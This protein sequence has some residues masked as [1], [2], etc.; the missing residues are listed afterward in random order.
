[1]KFKFKLLIIPAV[2]IAALFFF[3][4]RISENIFSLSAATVEMSEPT[5]PVITIDVN[6]NEINRLHGYVSNLDEMIVRETITPINS[7]KTLTVLIDEKELIV[8]KLKY[9]IYNIEGREVE[10]DTF[11]VL[12]S[13]DGTKKVKIALK[14]TMK[15]GQEYILK[16]T[17][18]TNQSKRIY[19][20]SRIKMYNDGHLAEKLKFATDFHSTLLGDDILAKQQ[21]TKYLESTRASDNSTYARVNIKSSYDM[22]TWGNLEPELIWEDVPTITEFYD[23]MASIQLKSIVSIETDNGTEFYVVKENFR[24]NYTDIRTYLYNYDRTMEA[25][26]DVNNTSLLINEFKLGITNESDAQTQAS[27]NNKYFTFVYGRELMLYDYD[28]N[29]LVRVFSFRNGKEDYEEDFYDEHS[30]RLIKVHDNGNVDFEVYGYMN[31]GEYE[32]R[33]GIVLYRYIHSD[34]RIEEQM[35]IPIS[36][37]YQLLKADMTD[38]AYLSDKDIFYFSLFDAI[39]AYDITTK[40]IECLDEQIPEEKMVYCAEENYLA[41]QDHAEDTQAANICILDLKSKEIR[42]IPALPGESIR[43]YGRINDNFIYGYARRTDVCNLTDG[44]NML[45]A[46][47]LCI[48]DFEGNVLKTYEKE[49]FYIDGIEIGENILILKRLVRKAGESVS[50]TAAADDSIMNRLIEVH[51]PMEVTRRI[52]DRI[53][54]EYYVA[55]PMGIDITEIPALETTANTIINFDT[56]TR[57]SEPENRA[58]QYYAYSFGEVIYA[59][60]DAAAVIQAAD[61]QTGTVINRDGRLV[62]ERGVKSTRAE[63]PGIIPVNT[64]EAHNSIQAAMKM[65]MLYKNLDTDTVG[66]NRYESSIGDWLKANM[67]STVVDMSGATLDEVLYYVYKSRPVL[68]VKSDGSACVITAY[69]ELN[70]T[71]YE[72]Q[73]KKSVSYSIKEAAKMFE[74]AGNV[75][76]SYVD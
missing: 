53:L 64:D 55:L 67:K 12:D 69:N 56:T 35:Y 40:Q 3:N 65:L 42:R 61:S 38:F 43:L 33:V 13:D 47:R 25:V 24:F 14:E 46:Y 31:R 22:V 52:T 71:V 57:L 41:W 4:G 48:E 50:Y 8:K 36:T 10:S 2:F 11:T 17:I 6:G 18:I 20:Y 49:G 21:L 54:T 7:L 26:F 58:K 72:P 45:P 66:Y 34:R 9:E 32:G 37:S 44:S 51:K 28:A 5:L 68:A 74:E 23:S 27:S 63:V 70:I 59:D 16:L 29:T 75:F 76:I 62:W 39:Y 15:T 73:K 30:V 1:M 19:Y 60:S